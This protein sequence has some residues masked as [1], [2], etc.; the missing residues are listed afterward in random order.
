MC[1]P[2][3]GRPQWAI[4]FHPMLNRLL[5]IFALFLALSPAAKAD[6]IADMLGRILPH[7]ADAKKFVWTITGDGTQQFTIASDGK[8][9]SV[10]GSDPIAV[11]TGINWYLQHY[12]GIDISWNS[13]TATLPRHLPACAP[14]THT[15]SVDW[16]YYL[17]FCTYS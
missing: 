10:S 16:R 8:Q 12:A 5:L 15:A 4:L 3:S 7:N 17:N 13:P 14:Q 11:A 2:P 1:V 9:V 6:P